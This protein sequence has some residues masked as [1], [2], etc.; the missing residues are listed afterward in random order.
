MATEKSNHQRKVGKDMSFVG[1]HITDEGI[2][3]FADSKSSILFEDGRQIEDIK[4]GK[5]QKVFKNKNFILVTYGNNEI[6][7][8]KNKMK[9]EDYINEQINKDITYEDFIN[10]F[11]QDILND[12]PEYNDGIYYFIIGTKDKKDR[13]CIYDVKI[14]VNEEN[15]TENFP[16][17]KPLYQ[18]FVVGG[19][20]I[21]M[22]TYMAQTFYH[23]IS[24]KQYSSHIKK[25]VECI[26]RLE[27]CFNKYRYNSVGVPVNIEIFQ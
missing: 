16:I 6:F 2:I 4:R 17:P 20:E 26:I 10:S 23:D 5:I 12:K 24:I 9:M 21:Y 27:N 7:S 25:V 22:N 18:G 3:A 11:Y 14:N 19:N 15:H 1:M 13:Y 8:A